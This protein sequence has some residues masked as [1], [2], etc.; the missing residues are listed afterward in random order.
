MRIEKTISFLLSRTSGFDQTCLF[1]ES[2]FRVTSAA[3]NNNIFFR[4]LFDLILIISYLMF[5]VAPWKSFNFRRYQVF[6]LF[7]IRYSALREGH[8]SFSSSYG[9]LKAFEI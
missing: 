2:W 6:F 3:V 9:I 1:V 4:I 5:S 7:K 8:M